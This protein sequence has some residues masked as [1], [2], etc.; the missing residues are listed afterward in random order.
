M[1]LIAE[2]GASKIQWGI[3]NNYKVF[4]FKTSGF[5]PNISDRNYLR[6]LLVSGF[7]DSFNPLHIKQIQYFGAGCSSDKNKKEVNRAL[8]NFFVNA[9]NIEIFTDL[10]AA[11]MALYKH[12]SGYVGIL[13][14]GSAFG[15]FENGCIKYQAPSLGYLLGDEG[16]GAHI[17]KMFIS[18]L[19]L[20][21]YSKKI[22]DEFYKE[23]STDSKQLIIDVYKSS[24]PNAFLAS[25]TPFVKKH[26][27]DQA[28]QKLVQSSFKQFVEKSI[29]PTIG[30]EKDFSIGIVGGIAH[31]FQQDIFNLFE[32]YKLNKPKIIEHPFQSLISSVLRSCK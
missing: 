7:P 20:N 28:I 30:I 10:E 31:H 26:I 21:E 5:N 8:Q 11:G 22:T 4:E 25:L 13:G 14:T 9:E 18:K 17:G 29:L 6:Q 23:Y 12:E 24:K 2:A 16:S 32:S 1:K 3:V 15:Y 19:L 27:K